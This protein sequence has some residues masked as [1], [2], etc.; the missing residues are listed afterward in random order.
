MCGIAGVWTRGAD[1]VSG[2]LLAMSEHMVPRGPDDDGSGV[3]EGPG[4]RLGLAARRLAI[5]DPSPL[6]HQPMHDPERGT[7][8]VFNGMIYNF[9]DLRDRL[10][11]DG[12][13]FTSRCDTEVILKAYGR[14]G[15]DC[16][17]HLR[18]MF[19]FAIWDPRENR[20]FL[21]RDRLGIKPL[22]YAEQ[23]GRFLFASEVK[24]LLAS[25]LVEPRLSSPGIASFL[26]F[27]ATS[28]PLTAIDGV[29]ALPAGHRASY[30]DGELR[31][32]P[33]WEPETEPELELGEEEAV[34]G[35]RELLEDAVGRHLVSDAPLGVFLSGGVD[36][37]IL[38]CLAARATSKLRTISVVFENSELS[39]DRWMDAVTER[40]GGEHV[41]VSLTPSDLLSWSTDAFR[42]MD[43]PSFDGVN[44]Y[45][46]SRAAS[47][48]GLKVALS[49]LGA[50]ELFDGYGYGRRIVALERAARLPKPLRLAIAG[51]APLAFRGTHR[52]KALQWLRGD[53]D[54]FS[55]YD[56]FRRLFH[57]DDMRTVSRTSLNG[58]PSPRALE[59]G[60]DLYGQLSVLELTGYMK[61]V[62]L[63]DTDSVSMANS[64]EVRVPFLDHPLVEWVLRLPAPLKAGQGKAL[65]LAATR[66]VLP[67]EVLDRPKMGFVLPLADWMRNELR[68]EVDRTLAAL[69][70]A[71]EEQIDSEAVAAVWGSFQESGRNWLRSW[72]LYALC[73][74]LEGVD[75]ARPAAAAGR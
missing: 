31:V 61:N 70:P 11:H 3:F 22:Y 10:A 14:Y 19:A 54:G 25:G 29:L 13:R 34:R 52:A 48:S 12:E 68:S 39:E 4:F 56:L 6:G 26:A 55:S 37:S 73:R 71:L 41:R 45:V 36:S 47:G 8:I 35:L 33:F 46:V 23:D 65:L 66:D 69:P 40:I 38:A 63:R 64:L 24:A 20:L 2:P 43:Q 67:P 44:T 53:R 51:A 17:R 62:L 15:A 74:W 16:V 75:T 28:E 32:E 9:E 58:V 7:T 5:I 42:A 60:R 18:G 72:A 30:E 50:D 49:G 57:P 27:G 21:A 1:D 59:A